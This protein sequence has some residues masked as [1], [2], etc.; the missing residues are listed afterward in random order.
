[1]DQPDPRFCD[2]R[3]WL[4]EHGDALYRY[5]LV[6]VRNAAAAEDL[7]Q[8]T[9]LAALTARERF[10][11][12]SSVRTWLIAILKNKLIDHLRR[13][14]REAPP[15]DEP[16]DE[17]IDELFEDDPGQHWRSAP[18]VWANPSGA[19]EQT[20]FWQVFSDC[21]AQLPP[22][23]AQAFGLCELDGLAGE[24][25][26]KVLGLSPSNLWVLM[27]RARLRLRQCLETRW[28]GKAP[29]ASRC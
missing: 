21:L 23:Q 29:D 3:T 8:E 22:R 13:R 10:A 18:G 24:E 15:V 9:L 26:C 7:V 27:H 2:P 11:G 20:E 5:A 12:Q 17:L 28:F 1:M 4:D 14:A 16:D 6:R 19:L 25:A